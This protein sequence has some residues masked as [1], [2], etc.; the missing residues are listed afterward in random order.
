MNHARLMKAT[1][2]NLGFK[3]HCHADAT[4]DQML[5]VVQNHHAPFQAAGCP[6]GRRA[7]P[8]RRQLISCPTFS[9]PIYEDTKRIHFPYF[10]SLQPPPF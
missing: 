8:S 7:R 5:A 1:F 6:T 2:E 3:I 9:F 4:N 10:V